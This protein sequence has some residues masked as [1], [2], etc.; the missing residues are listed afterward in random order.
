ME[1]ILLVVEADQGGPWHSSVD[2]LRSCVF[3]IR[4]VGRIFITA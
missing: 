1:R 2:A 4:S 3:S